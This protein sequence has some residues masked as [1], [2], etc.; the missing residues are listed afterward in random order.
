MNKITL[1]ANTI[2]II[3]KTAGPD[4]PISLWIPSLKHPS[5]FFI[6]EAHN[7]SKT[8]SALHEPT[9]YLPLIVNEGTLVIKFFFLNTN[10]SSK[11]L[12]LRIFL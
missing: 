8:Y 11:I 2:I 12:F 7:A 9:Y 6:K 3:I 1:I 10:S 4:N 5:G